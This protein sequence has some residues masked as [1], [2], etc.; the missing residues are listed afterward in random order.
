MFA[1]RLSVKTLVNPASLLYTLIPDAHA[2]SSLALQRGFLLLIAAAS[3][4]A[5]M[6]SAI[7]N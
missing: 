6:I 5:L 7:Y 1:N 3:G 4:L 2:L